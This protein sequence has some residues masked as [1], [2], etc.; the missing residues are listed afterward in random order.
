MMKK[1][2]SILAWWKQMGRRT[3]AQAKELL[4]LTDAGGNNSSRSRLWKIGCQ[5]LAD[6]TGLR[7]QVSH[8]PPG[9]SKWNKIEHCMF[10]F[11]T[12]NW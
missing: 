9:T 4:I 6:R 3:C 5:R 12:Q 2:D 7:I 8:F 1:S 11:I 10:S